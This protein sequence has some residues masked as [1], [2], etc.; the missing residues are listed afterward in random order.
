MATV[1]RSVASGF[2]CLLLAFSSAP[3]RA[4]QV[5]VF[6]PQRIAVIRP[7]ERTEGPRLLVAFDLTS[8]G[9]EQ[10][11]D[12]AQLT[13]Y[14]KIRAEQDMPRVARLEV[15]P[16]TTDWQADAVGWDTP[17]NNAGA[18]VDSSLQASN[19]FPVAV[20]DTY[21]LWFDITRIARSWKDGSGP[22]RGVIIRASYFAP[23]VLEDI[24]LSKTSLSI[25]H[26]AVRR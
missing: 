16:L 18:D 26:H 8:V 24:D 22:N 4:G 1:P 19:W 3:V 12:F 15:L 17:W 20:T 9:I 14:G 10:H 21:D 23:S 25:W 13:F 11:I 5:S 2:L 6:S 7:A